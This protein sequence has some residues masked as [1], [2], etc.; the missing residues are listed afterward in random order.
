MSEASE[1]SPI[2]VGFFM[3]YLSGGTDDW[4]NYSEPMEIVF[5]DGHA[6]GLIDRPVEIHYRGAQGLPKGSV[7]EAIDA[8]GEL[9]DE[10]CV[11]VIGPHIGENLVGR[12]G[13]D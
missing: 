8:F 2:K 9:V 3:D 11:A 10:G 7:K 1:A 13:V 4:T 6:A 5:R 12:Y